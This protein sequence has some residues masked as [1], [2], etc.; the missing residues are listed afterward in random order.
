GTEIGHNGWLATAWCLGLAVLGY[1]W[2][3]SKF[4]DQK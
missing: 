2:S 1:L 4:D 3:T